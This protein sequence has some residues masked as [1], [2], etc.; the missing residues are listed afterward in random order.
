MGFMRGGITREGD[1]SVKE[2]LISGKIFLALGF[3][4]GWFLTVITV[5]VHSFS[6]PCLFAFVFSLFQRMLEAI[7]GESGGLAVRMEHVFSV[8]LPWIAL[9]LI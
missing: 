3:Y 2:V 6:A 4:C 7:A 5:F 8:Q 1:E 9:Y